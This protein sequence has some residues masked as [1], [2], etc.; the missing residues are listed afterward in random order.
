MRRGRLRDT[1]QRVTLTPEADSHH[2]AS[3]EGSSGRMVL[4]DTGCVLGPSYRRTLSLSAN[5]P[6][7][8]HVLRSR[9]LPLRAGIPNAWF[10]ADLEPGVT[11]F[12]VG[13]RMMLGVRPPGRSL[14]TNRRSPVAFGRLVPRTDGGCDLRIS[15][16]RQGFPYRAVEDPSAEDFFDDWVAT[17]ASELGAS[18]GATDAQQSG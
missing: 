15:L 8:R 12:M 5:T 1:P 9:L 16:Y 17:V 4:T 3:A 13:G 7:A 6:T 14:W 18:R 10:G 11:G 2:N